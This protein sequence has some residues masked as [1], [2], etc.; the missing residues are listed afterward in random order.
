MVSHLA[1][2]LPALT[3]PPINYA[4]EPLC[5]LVPKCHHQSAAM[6]LDFLLDFFPMFLIGF[7]RNISKPLLLCVIALNVNVT[8]AVIEDYAEFCF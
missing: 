4:W 5:H 3:S 2:S 6:N 7:V 8:V 1:T